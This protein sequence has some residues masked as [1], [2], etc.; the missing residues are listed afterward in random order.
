MRHVGLTDDQLWQAIAE[1]TNAMSGL[2]HQ[3][4][5]L[6]EKLGAADPADR[7]KLMCSHLEAINQYQREYRNYTAELRRR[8]PLAQANGQAI[9]ADS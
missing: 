7:A 6:D 1:N 3:Q 8:Y 4:L 9:A 5:E 2:L